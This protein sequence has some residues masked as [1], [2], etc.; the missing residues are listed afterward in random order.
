MKQIV[1]V[2][3][4]VLSFFVLF[5]HMDSA[6][7]IN[8]IQIRRP[9]TRT[10]PLNLR[11][12]D[13][14][15]E[16]IIRD[17]NYANTQVI[18][19]HVPEIG[20]EVQHQAEYYSPSE[21]RRTPQRSFSM[22]KEEARR[23]RNLMHQVRERDPNNDLYHKH[24]FTYLGRV[25]LHLPDFHVIMRN[26]SAPIDLD[27]IEYK[28]HLRDV[29]GATWISPQVK[30]SRPLRQGVTENGKVSKIR[31]FGST[32]AKDQFDLDRLARKARMSERKKTTKR[33]RHDREALGKS[34]RQSALRRT[35][36]MNIHPK[37]PYGRT[38][39]G[40]WT[41]RRL[42]AVQEELRSSYKTNRFPSDPLVKDQWFIHGGDYDNRMR[43]QRSIPI[44]GVVFLNVMPVWESKIDGQGT[45]IAVVDDGVNFIHSDLK[46][47]F[48]PMLSVDYAEPV[49]ISPASDITEHER[50]ELIH[51]MRKQTR[52]GLPLV[53][54]FH[55]TAVAS[56]A[57]GSPSDG[58][59]GTGVAP[60]AMLS[61]IRVIGPSEVGGSG[62][63]TGHMLT[64]IQE[65]L[66]LSYRCIHLDP[67][68]GEQK[69]ENMV[70]V[71]SWG[72]EGSTE[73]IP[74]RASPIVTAAIQGCVEYGRYG[75]GSIYV[76]A[77]GNAKQMYDSVD[78][79]GYA[80]MRYVIAVGSMSRTG[81][82]LRYSEGGESL[83]VSAPSS[84]GKRGIVTAT[85]MG[86]FF[87]T[88]METL[89]NYESEGLDG[90]DQSIQEDD[91]RTSLSRTGCTSK[92]GG[93]S[94][95]APMIAG[96]VSMMLQANHKLTWKDVQDILIRSCDKPHYGE[97]YRVDQ[98][99]DPH[100][101]YREVLPIKLAKERNDNL[102][103]ETRNDEQQSGGGGYDQEE[104]LN[105]GLEILN[106]IKSSLYIFYAS[107]DR[108][109]WLENPETGLHHSR[110][111]G[112]GIPDVNAAIT[113]SKRRGAPEGEQSEDPDRK[114]GWEPSITNDY[115][116]QSH[117]IVKNM[118][119]YEFSAPDNQHDEAKA[120]E[121]AFM[122]RAGK[123]DYYKRDGLVRQKEI[124]AWH[125]VLN[126]TDNPVHQIYTIEENTRMTE[127]TDKR[128][129]E[130]FIIEHVQLY[131][132]AT[133]PGGISN[134]Q[135]ALCDR[136]SLCSI[137]VQGMPYGKTTGT[138]QQLD[139]A[140]TSVKYWGQRNPYDGGWIILIRNIYPTQSAAIE[141]HELTLQIYGHYE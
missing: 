132:N 39:T 17:M 61:S 108:L 76:M 5:S 36:L 18:V 47:K 31:R 45:V 34:L 86:A 72:P 30:Q 107:P 24:G 84:D 111:I 73:Q 81:Y 64:E 131:V 54:Q 82:P 21:R 141:V 40:S 106:H 7:G 63:G 134:S 46:Q 135:I 12:E 51:E 112:F 43:R 124:T 103:F 35:V 1:S 49:Y 118:I 25:S 121:E 110:L 101:M 136:T 14:V 127:K 100:V 48:V 104:A 28:Q 120:K 19:F 99:T 91:A 128:E 78:L 109:E 67:L 16:T 74:T 117:N 20:E 133:M 32:R 58:T 126:P 93:T 123:G 83:L 50:T 139:Y 29:F 38:L 115:V 13:V 68:T 15:P 77:A 2:I 102:F 70:F 52:N 105:K 65:S 55:G 66:A 4:G 69:L 85:T 27:S 41:S 92:F 10:N 23:S 96:V 87:D 130:N 42:Q 122:E 8:V 138:E 9:N 22:K 114:F 140:F 80:S 79:D 137:F 88:R 94:A 90:T 98:P 37:G 129:S 6:D 125:I 97:I 11:S 71:V 75:Y 44:P 33:Q 57:A 62:V 53:G 59:C 116:V 95:S 113:M 3:L 60:G 89:S 119:H 56:I 26:D